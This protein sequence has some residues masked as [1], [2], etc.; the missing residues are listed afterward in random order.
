MPT[1]TP[2]TATVEPTPP[3]MALPMPMRMPYGTA[4]HTASIR[5][6]ANRL[7]QPAYGGR[8]P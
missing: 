4:M 1:T 6:A 2:S 3:P 8:P 5:R 7:H